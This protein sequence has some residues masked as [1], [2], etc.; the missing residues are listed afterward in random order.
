MDGVTSMLRD[1]REVKNKVEIDSIHFGLFQATLLDYYL[2]DTAG[3]INFRGN[4]HA[5][6]NCDVAQVLCFP[7]SAILS[8]LG[9][10]TVHYFSLDVESFELDVLRGIPFNQVD[11]KVKKSSKMAVTEW[12]RAWLKQFGLTIN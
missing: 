9:V 8:A 6:R 7:L 3:G 11:I 12:V 4:A 10:K 5:G 2:A 1:S